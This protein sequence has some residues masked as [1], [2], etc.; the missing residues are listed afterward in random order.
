MV[1]HGVL[2]SVSVSIS[3]MRCYYRQSIATAHSLRASFCSAAVMTKFIFFSRRDTTLTATVYH[4][5]R[6]PLTASAST[7]TL[8]ACTGTGGSPAA[9][10][11]PAVFL[12]LLCSTVSLVIV[13]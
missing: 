4:R 6:L 12:P 10:I 1:R 2:Q 9:A 7:G 8:Y 13:G 5:T 11:A 3:G